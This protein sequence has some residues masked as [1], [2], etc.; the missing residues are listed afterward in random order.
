M[1]QTHLFVISM[2]CLLFF[3]LYGCNN[4]VG[5]E[6]IEISAP[7]RS[8]EVRI[9]ARPDEDKKISFIVVAEKILIDWGD[10]TTEEFTPNGMPKGLV[11]EYMEQ[12]LMNIT[13]HTEEMVNFGA[14]SMININ[15]VFMQTFGRLEEIYFGKCTRLEEVILRG[16]NLIRLEIEEANSLT[17]FD[18]SFN[19]L[20]A[21]TLNSLFGSLP[22][23]D[24]GI[25]IYRENTGSE[26]C[27]SIIVLSK[28]W[29]VQSLLP[30]E[31]W[32]LVSQEID[33]E[34]VKLYA[35]HLFA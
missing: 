27:D 10:G 8:G 3:A 5:D 29:T 13:I 18:C 22:F 16:N 34:M 15:G 24:E 2:L 28:G 17:L 35:I 33:D 26:T 14:C 31:D 12:N 32:E 25:I 9:K 11:H 21:S 1:K 7:L 4:P 23:S 6:I 19:S 30:D 20:S